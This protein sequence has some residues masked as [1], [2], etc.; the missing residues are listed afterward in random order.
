[1]LDLARLTR[2]RWGLHP[3]LA[4]A[5]KKYG[6][7]PNVI[8][9]EQDGIRAYLGRPDYR[10][11][12]NVFSSEQFRYVREQDHYICPAD[13]VL[14][15]S[16]YDRQRQV[17]MYRTSAKICQACH[18]K[19]QC[20]TS[21]YA[22]IVIRSIDQD[23]LDR[24]EQYR[25]TPAYHKA[26]RKRSVWIEPMFGEAKQWH[27]LHKCRWRG[28]LKVNMQA[29]ITATGQ[30]IKRLLKHTPS[31]PDPEPPIPKAN[32][33]PRPSLDF[34]LPFS[35]SLSAQLRCFFNRL[36]WRCTPGRLHAAGRDQPGDDLVD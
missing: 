35:T 26:Q 22:R 27:N 12:H 34:W 1:M 5:D 19:P 6:T 16:S 23:I 18:L 32:A 17:F 29:L 20:T 2:F 8:G 33:L 28:L 10:Q 11:R 36:C 31:H 15:N 30:N 9:L 13:E 24:V 25:T 3:H 14:P 4:V 7:V 21:A